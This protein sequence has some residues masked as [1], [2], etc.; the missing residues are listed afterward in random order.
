MHESDMYLAIVEEGCEKD[1][2]RTILRLGEQRFG[3]PSEP[4]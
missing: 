4:I 1:A 3:P 2:K